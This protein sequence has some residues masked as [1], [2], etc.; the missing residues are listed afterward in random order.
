[1]DYH[2]LKSGSDIRGVAIEGPDSPVTLSDRAAMELT[3]AFAVWLAR[4]TGRSQLTVAV[5]HDSRL[6]AGRLLAAV[7]RG[8][9]GV[10]V[11]DCGLCTTPAMF[12]TCVDEQTRCDGAVMI[13]A[14]HLPADRNGLKFVTAQGGLEP[15]QIDEIITLAEAGS[16]LEGAGS[17]KPVNY[18]ARYAQGLKQRI[19]QAFPG[20]KLPLSGMHIVVDAGGGVGGFYAHEVLEPLGADVSGS[21]F[22]Q[23]DG[24]FSGHIPNPEDAGAMASVCEATA[25]AGADLGVIFDADM[26][27][28]GA[29]LKGGVGL[30]R[31][32]L[33]A[34]MSAMVLAQCPG[35]TIVTDSVT[36]SGLAQFIADHGGRHH[37]FKRGY[38]NVI[39][40]AQR[41][42]A[43]G[44]T[45]PMAMET[46]GH[47]AL[48]ENYFLDDGA[49]MVTK[50]IIFAAQLRAKG[51][52][53]EDLLAGLK[54]PLDAVEIRL[55][56]PLDR[57]REF[58][59]EAIHHVQDY[60]KIAPGWSLAPDNREGIR[61]NLDPQHGDGWFLLR[62]SV[63]DPVMPLNIESDQ[64][65][66]ALVIA[67]QLMQLIAALPGVDAS[68]L[69]R[70]IN[71]AEREQSGKGCL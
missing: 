68:A 14:S 29:V 26:D 41:L 53:L 61:V 1:V 67:R 59:Q 12:M 23:P 35:G 9:A 10:Q 39:D 25:R 47:C 8:L 24:A 5:G 64:A 37:R 7:K 33:V 57:F 69:G 55:N 56:L 2:K 6:S 11:L 18:L 62:M 28:A 49:Y 15:A 13:T 40:E 22:L 46:S 42:V 27:R 30:Y 70:Y 43:E 32:R 52:S 4:R 48:A 51:R 63:H 65:G 54:E 50:L 38:K 3:A 31:N 19:A 44:V 60:A 71:R 21:Q 16:R 36:S 66:G 17:I 20:V 34:L 58:G 45:C